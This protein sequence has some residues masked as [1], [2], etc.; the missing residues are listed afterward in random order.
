MQDKSIEARRLETEWLQTPRSVK[1]SNAVALGT[2][3]ALVAGGG[4]ESL[5]VMLPS[6]I[7]AYFLMRPTAPLVLAGMIA[8]GK[9]SADYMDVGQS[10]VS[11]TIPALTGAAL[12]V[13]AGYAA[14]LGSKR[15]IR[16]L[17]KP[18]KHWLI[19]FLPVLYL[20][21]YLALSVTLH[22]ILSPGGAS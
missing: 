22:A 2:A 5:G 9:V 10:S 11:A 21:A 13:L 4:I 1:I 3:M 16:W 12:Y 20:A 18:E 7:A 17:Q 15:L 8:F 14:Y 19:T 6:G